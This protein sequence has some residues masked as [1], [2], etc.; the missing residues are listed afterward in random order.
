[1]VVRHVYAIHRREGL[2]GKDAA[3]FR[4]EGWE[5]L[6]PWFN[7]LLFSGG[8]SICPGESNSCHIIVFLS[9]LMAYSNGFTGQQCA[10]A[11]ASYTF[12][13]VFR[14]FSEIEVVPEDV[15]KPWIENLMLTC[16][17]NS[18]MCSDRSE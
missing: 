10:M 17:V 7:Y 12:T 3:E 4:P 14:S 9:A 5:R 8:L 15:H 2:W 1:M 6:L 11:E 16:V 18:V 13:R